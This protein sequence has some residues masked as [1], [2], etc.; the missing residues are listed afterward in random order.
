MNRREF[1]VRGAAGLAA[2][3]AMRTRAT[4][5]DGGGE[6]P[7]RLGV[8]GVG[9]RGTY[10]VQLA[11]GVPGVSVSAVCD[12]NADNVG[13]AIGMAE[14]HQG[15]A[16]A[17]YTKGPE[18]YKD[19][20]TREDVDAV[21]I[22]APT[23][24]HCTMAIDAM[25]AGKHVGSEVPAGFEPDELWDLVRTKEK[26][27]RRYMLLEN[28]AYSRRNMMILE[29]ARAGVFGETYYGECSYI[30]DCR[31]ML[32][33]KD[34]SLDWWGEWCTKHYGNDYPTH[35]MGPLAKWLGI[36]EGDR[37]ES[38][39]SRMSAPRVL[40]LYAEKRFGKD[41]PQAKLPWV[42][43]EFIATLIQTHAGR[44]IRIDYDV[45]SPRPV[46]N[47]YLIQGTLGVYD[48]RS[49]TYFDAAGDEKWVNADTHLAQYD[50]PYWRR[51]G[52][53]AGKAGHGGGD[54]FVIR[55][56]IEMAR[57]DREPWIDVYDAA[58]WSSIF[59]ASRVS[60]D[61]KGAPVD[62]PDFT[63]GRWKDPAWRRGSMRPA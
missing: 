62:L 56:F 16:P 13:R 51:V 15:R 22:A 14:K 28:Y 43:G 23:K 25:R 46:A 31:F 63:G 45:N 42:Q 39:C 20:L 61:R 7:V 38:C 54:Y 24:W 4:A 2:A 44:L 48:S 53:E 50:H 40:R 36:H 3:A 49:G 47:H 12:L 9:S 57:Q 18:A 33:K 34:G 21:L 17:A 59:H 29:M 11:L 19:M 26:T 30:H 10:L 37:L 1:L 6:K 35:G 58:A 27:G 55:D 5:D 32:F 52:D 41:S 8:I 60:I